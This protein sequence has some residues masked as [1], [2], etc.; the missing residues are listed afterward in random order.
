[1]DVAMD[2]VKRVSHDRLSHTNDR[3]CTRMKLLEESDVYTAATVVV[4]FD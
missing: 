1:M 2:T 4:A 3:C